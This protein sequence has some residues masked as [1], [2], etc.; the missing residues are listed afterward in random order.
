MELNETLIDVMFKTFKTQ[1]KTTVTGNII[2]FRLFVT[3]SKSLF[4]VKIRKDT[5]KEI[6]AWINQVNNDMEE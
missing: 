2:E 5:F 6:F 4:S 3:D 1:I